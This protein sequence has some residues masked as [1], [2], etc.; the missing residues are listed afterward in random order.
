MLNRKIIL[1]LSFA[2]GFS[3]MVM[4]L[5]AARI[6]APILGSSVYTWTS[7]IGIVLLGT[8]VG[9][10]LGGKFIDKKNSIYAQGIF[11]WLAS[12]S[13]L[14]I[15]VFAKLIK[16]IALMETPLW[17]SVLLASGFLFLIPSFFLGATYPIILKLYLQNISSAGKEAGSISAFWAL[18]SILG[19]FLT[20]F[21]FVGYIGSNNTLFAVSV[22]LFFCSL[23]LFPKNK[24]LLLFSFLYLIVF[25]VSFFIQNSSDSSQAIIFEKE[26][27][28]FK[29][30]VADENTAFF[31]KTRIL[32]LDA[33]S[34]SVENR[35]G[36]SSDIYTNFCPAFSVFIDSDISNIA[37]LGG[38]SLAISENF[39][40]YYPSAA[41]TTA[42]IDPLVTKTAEK[43][44]NTSPYVINHTQTEDGRLFLLRSEKKFDIIFSDAYNSFISVPWH[45]TTREFFQLAKNKLEP[46]GAFAINFI[47]T[48]SGRESGLY[49]SLGITFSSVFDNFYVFSYGENPLEI[50]NIILVGINSKKHLPNSNVQE[51]LSSLPNGDL[52]AKHFDETAKKETG[53]IILTDNF[54]PTDRLMLP[55]INSYFP[56]YVRSFKTNL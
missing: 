30:R 3:V 37:V 15:P 31:K 18:G 44:F 43:Y 17:I 38:G 9:N 7:V 46:D 56:K 53:A 28:Y 29:I 51:K 48:R 40:K 32:F 4:E 49:Q 42:E 54:A 6:I 2:A 8:S 34:H 27:N 33:D 55:A 22:I 12:I 35:D 1:F 50:Q 47:S 41:V 13:I 24:N 11:F 20:G 14:F 52:L 36:S 10:F 19:T 5:T 39:K 23:W 26:S 16:H 21:V 45:L 25:F